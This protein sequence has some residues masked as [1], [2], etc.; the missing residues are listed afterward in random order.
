MRLRA[1]KS[2]RVNMLTMTA[3]GVPPPESRPARGAWVEIPN[4]SR[5]VMPVKVAPRRGRVD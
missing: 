1:R 2:R 5:N 3:L 4:I